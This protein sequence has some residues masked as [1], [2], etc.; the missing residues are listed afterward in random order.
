MR[1]KPRISARLA[2]TMIWIF[3][4]GCVTEE[5]LNQ[6]T[7]LDS[8]LIYQ[9]AN[10]KIC[11]VTGT[12]NQQWYTANIRAASR[13]GRFEINMEVDSSLS[14]TKVSVPSYI[15]TRGRDITHSKFLNQF[16]Q[17]NPQSPLVVG[18]DIQAITGAT[19]SSQSMTEQVRRV[20]KILDD[21]GQRE[22]TN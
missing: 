18:D 14:I 21:I 1:M 7:P 19:L 11:K 12:M 9:D 8:K 20:I 5:A 2:T 22:D 16:K 4:A 10:T 3:I 13:S 6:S 15:G 17:R